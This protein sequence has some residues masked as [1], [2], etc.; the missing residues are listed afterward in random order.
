MF[1]ERENKDKNDRSTVILTNF[2][3]IGGEMLFTCINSIAFNYFLEIVVY[4]SR[5][6]ELIQPVC[7]PHFLLFNS[8]SGKLPN[9]YSLGSSA[10]PTSNHS[11]V[12]T[13]HLVLNLYVLFERL[14]SILTI[15]TLRNAPYNFTYQT[16]PSWIGM[17]MF[18]A[19]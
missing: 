4:L 13:R 9:T 11:A 3:V 7:S 12:I 5:F 19:T 15:K 8:W 17:Y 18:I 16:T 10:R 14:N 1:P 6:R 2:N